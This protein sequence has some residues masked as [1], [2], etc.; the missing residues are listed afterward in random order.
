MHMP[1]L[2]GEETM[3]G[4]LYLMPRVVKKRQIRLP[5]HAGKPAHDAIL[6]LPQLLLNHLRQFSSEP[7]LYNFVKLLVYFCSNSTQ[8]TRLCLFYKVRHP[9]F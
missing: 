7:I 5:R 3:N 8:N 2:L 4:D 9:L 6:N 1:G